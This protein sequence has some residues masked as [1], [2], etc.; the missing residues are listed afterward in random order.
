MNQAFFKTQTIG[1]GET[2]NNFVSHCRKDGKGFYVSHP[3]FS[4]S[5]NISLCFDG[6]TDR[7]FLASSP[8]IYSYSNGGFTLSDY[9][10]GWVGCTPPPFILLS[11]HYGIASNSLS[12]TYKSVCHKLY[13]GLK[14]VFSVLTSNL[15]SLYVMLCYV[16]M[17]LIIYLS[18]YLGVIVFKFYDIQECMLCCR[19]NIARY[20]I[21][22]E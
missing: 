14:N 19:H 6:N 13:K 1:E 3:P 12:L 8:M 20:Y 4:L 10:V 18:I 17:L 21:L 22:M 7:G 9:N 11:P 2:S 16:I 15:Q 5:P